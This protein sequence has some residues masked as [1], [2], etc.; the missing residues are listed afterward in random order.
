MSR[1]IAVG[2]NLR[3]LPRN[4][5]SGEKKQNRAV[6]CSAIAFNYADHE[7]HAMS[8]RHCTES[9]DGRSGNIHCAF[10]VAAKHR[11]AFERPHP[12][13]C[14]EVESLGIAGN[15]SLR[16]DHK[17]RTGSGGFGNE[18]SHFGER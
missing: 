1:S 13:S 5:P 12:D 15:K 8:L 3:C 6:K 17:K 9:F 14:A 10:V 11:T 18:R 7:M 2:I 16:K 4:A